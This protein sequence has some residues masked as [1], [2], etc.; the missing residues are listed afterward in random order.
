[1]ARD[2][3]RP[4]ERRRLSQRR[5]QL[6]KRQLM[7][8]ATPAAVAANIRRIVARQVATL[9]RIVTDNDAG[10]KPAEIIAALGVDAARLQSYLAEGSLLSRSDAVAA[11]V[12]RVARPLRNGF[13][14]IPKPET[15]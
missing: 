13:V 15:P 10:H 5:A 12:T 2:R 7:R 1:M 4:G 8:D 6:A 3:R 9:S 14:E 11:T